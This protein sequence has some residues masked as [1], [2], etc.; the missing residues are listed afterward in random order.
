MMPGAHASR[1]AGGGLEVAAIVP[2]LQARDPR[3]LDLRASLRDP[4]GGWWVRQF[5]QRSSIPVMLLVDVSASMGAARARDVRGIVAGFAHA[6]AQSVARVGDSFGLIAF[7][8]AP[9]PALMLPPTRVRQAAQ[10]MLSLLAQHGFDGG[11]ATHLEQLSALLPRQPALVFLLSD[12]CFPV[13]VLD[14]ALAHMPAHDVVP[15][16]LRHRAGGAAGESAA[17]SWGLIELFDAETQRLRTVWL[18]RSLR[19]R[20]RR[21]EAAHEDAVRQCLARHQRLP[22][23]IGPVFDAGAVTDYFAGRD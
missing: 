10:A 12:F 5:H 17:P 19:E 9:L 11:A 3:R 6:L 21:Q 23:E 1:V 14:E 22:L 7:D 16:W 18:R 20:W 4:F 8:R 2:L 13:D 15:V